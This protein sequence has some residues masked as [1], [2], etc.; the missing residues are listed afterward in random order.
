MCT[1][2]YIPFKDGT[3]LLASSR[4]E[5]PER[6]EVL[7]PQIVGH[8]KTNVLA[9]KDE[10]GGGTW[11]GASDAGRLALIMNGAYAPH[12]RRP[13][14]KKSRG[15]VV[16]ENFEWLSASAFA[17]G[18]DLAG[19]EPFTSVMIDT[20]PELRIFELKWDGYLKSFFELRTD[21][22]HIWSSENLFPGS[23]H[24]K[25]VIWFRDFIT[26][27]PQPSI[28]DAEDF[29]RNA[30]KNAKPEERI[31]M[32]KNNVVRT[33]SMTFVQYQRTGWTMKYSDLLKGGEGLTG[34][35]GIK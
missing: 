11:V 7:P 25:R 18:V 32:S 29:F 14:Y 23:V 34:E 6:G 13:P 27:N 12:K 16:S 10:K 20:L 3:F 24:R 17:G 28:Q 26:E 31:C 33:V 1:I 8:N 30:G 5:S 2:A 4:D 21:K 19:I 9:P 35:L 15:L 22:P